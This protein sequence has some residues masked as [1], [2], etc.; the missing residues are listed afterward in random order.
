MR[1]TRPLSPKFCFF[2]FYVDDRAAM[3]GQITKGLLFNVL[4]LIASLPSV[5]RSQTP[6]AIGLD[7][8]VNYTAN[9]LQVCIRDTPPW[10]RCAENLNQS[11]WSGFDVQLFRVAAQELNLKEGLE[12]NFKCVTLSDILE[13]IAIPDSECDVALGGL[14]VSPDRQAAGIRFS[15]P[16]LQSDLAIIVSASAVE[17][18]YGWAW[19]KPFDT[20]L[21]VAIILTILV[22]PLLI[23]LVE[24]LS[25]KRRVYASDVPEGVEEVTFCLFT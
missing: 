19:L 2:S 24:F 4:L 25:L 10:A 22:L 13:A 23:W 17:E 11:Q 15:W 7:P 8:S 5:V 18:N 20:S 14:A 12:Y 16:Y 3:T 9:P 6:F 21:W 1:Q